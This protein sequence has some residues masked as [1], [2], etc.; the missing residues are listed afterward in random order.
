MTRSYAEAKRSSGRSPVVND[1]NELGREGDIVALQNPDAGGFEGEQVRD[2][3]LA[4]LRVEA[5]VD[6][7]SFTENPVRL[8]GGFDTLIFAFSP[9]GAPQELAGPLI[10]RV[11]PDMAGQ[12]QAKKSCVPKRDG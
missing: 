4:F 1:Q 10:V 5:G 3:F 8:L 9:D 7:L 11:F 12:G 2:E 6:S